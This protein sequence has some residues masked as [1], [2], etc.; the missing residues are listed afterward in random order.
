M[1]LKKIAIIGGAMLVTA[2][3]VSG[4]GFGI[5]KIFDKREAENLEFEDFKKDLKE[6]INEF[7]N[8]ENKEEK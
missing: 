2:T 5:K 6:E 4:I 8:P 1:E 3:V 7:T